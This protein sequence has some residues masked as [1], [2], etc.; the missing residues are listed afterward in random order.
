MHRD[1]AGRLPCH[2]VMVMGASE[3]IKSAVADASPPDAIAAAQ[4]AS[5]MQ[6][7]DLTG[8]S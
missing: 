3:E 2:I 8:L 5:K 6:Q 4:L 1:G 7:N